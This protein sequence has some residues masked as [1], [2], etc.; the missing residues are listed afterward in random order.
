MTACDGRGASLATVAGQISRFFRPQL[1][2]VC[3]PDAQR[4]PE[5]VI[6]YDL[7]A[8]H[9][10]REAAGRPS[11][12]TSCSHRRAHSA[13]FRN[14][15]RVAAQLPELHAESRRISAAVSRTRAWDLASFPP[16]TAFPS[17][18]GAPR[19][20][21]IR[22]NPARTE[23]QTTGSGDDLMSVLPMRP[24]ACRTSAELWINS[25][26]TTTAGS[27]PRATFSQS[28]NRAATVTHHAMASSFRSF[29]DGCPCSAN[30]ACVAACSP[31]RVNSLADRRGRRPLEIGQRPNTG[32]RSI[33]C[34][35]ITAASSRWSYR[36][37][38]GRGPDRVPVK[39]G[40]RL[41]RAGQPIDEQDHRN[42]LIAQQ[43]A[44]I[45]AECVRD[46]GDAVLPVG[47]GEPRGGGISSTPARRPIP[48]I[49]RG[50]EPGVGVD[51]G[52]Q[53]GKHLRVGVAR[54]V[55]GDPLHRGT[56]EPPL[57]AI[58]RPG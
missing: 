55:P 3:A 2:A 35:V 37:V 48:C 47:E 6:G 39:V 30:S 19:R 33:T 34:L 16:V 24:R 56:A 18:W 52:G 42:G 17:H 28:G 54:D 25:S 13:A 27:L 23:S 14:S 41:L 21:S 36:M 44:P 50:G 40:E 9:R 57:G 11:R 1:R 58:R 12:V 53:R 10:D 43:A 20:Q 26:R 51:H 7:T 45:L 4:A 49:P 15:H 5:P 31:D 46:R 32:T 8:G 22:C 29:S 38:I